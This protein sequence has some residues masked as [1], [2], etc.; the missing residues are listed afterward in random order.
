M[1]IIHSFWSLPIKMHDNSDAIYRDRGGWSR[2][3]FYYMS[4]ALSCLKFKQLYGNIELVTDKYGKEV[5]YDILE[6]PYNSVKVEL[7]CLNNYNHQLWALGKLYA[8]SIQDE[9]FLHVDS[10]VYIWKKLPE[11]LIDGELI[12]QNNETNFEHNIQYVQSL[13]GKLDYFP[14]AMQEEMQRT[15]DVIEVNAGILGGKNIPFFKEYTR[16]AFEFVDKNHAILHRLAPNIGGFNMIF[17]QFLFHCLAQQKNLKV[18]LLFDSVRNLE[19]MALFYKIPNQMSY[20]HALGT[21]KKLYHIGADI[22]RL[23]L[24]EFPDYYY[25]IIELTRKNII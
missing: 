16:E 20:A 18:N 3:T 22:S 21:Y 1:K 5:L 13:K 23:L 6:L 24:N 7:D 15:T 8:Y 17:E 25:R 9:P 10:D 14:P 11:E 2:N 4:W 12:G 19:G